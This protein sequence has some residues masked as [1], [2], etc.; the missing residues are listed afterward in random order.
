YLEMVERMKGL[1]F[2]EFK[3]VIRD[4]RILKDE[5][6]NCHALVMPSL[7]ELFGLVFIE[8]ISQNTPVLY[9]NNEGIT[10]YLNNK[11]VGVAVDP[12]NELD[13][14]EGILKLERNYDSF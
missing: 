7:N 10:P 5:I 1:N 8:A 6:E 4:Q 12:R 2:V 9:P 11:K 14:E 3:G 13:I